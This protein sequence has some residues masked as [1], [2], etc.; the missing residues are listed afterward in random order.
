MSARE[1]DPAPPKPLAEM[2]VGDWNRVESSPEFQRLVAQRRRVVIPALIVFVLIFGTFT[3]L[4]AWGHHVMAH[5]IVS[6]F[7]VAY[8]FA[9][10]LIVMTWILA[11]VY[12]HA[13]NSRIDPLA[14][15]VASSV[16]AREQPA[17]TA[18]QRP[19]DDSPAGE[20]AP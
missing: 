4:A 7:S 17:E 16:G 11:R 9:L 13:S 8:A 5:Q 6:G 12:I 2:T 18:P 3:V 14:E 19:G 10:G 15:V 1:G 20:A